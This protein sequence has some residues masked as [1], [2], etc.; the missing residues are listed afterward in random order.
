MRA[1]AQQ[2]VTLGAPPYRFGPGLIRLVGT[3]LG[4]AGTKGFVQGFGLDQLVMQLATEWLALVSIHHDGEVQVIGRLGDQ[5]DRIVRERLHRRRQLGQQRADTTPNQ[6]DSGTVFQHGNP[7]DP[8]Q[9]GLE[10][11]EHCGRECG[12]IVQR[13]G[14]AG[15]R[16]RDQVDRY[17]MA[18]EGL[19]RLGQEAGGSPHAAGVKGDQ[20]HAIL[21]RNRLQA[22]RVL[23][24]CGTD[25]RARQLAFV[26]AADF[27]LDTGIADGRDGARMQD[28]G[29]H[30]GDFLGLVITQ[31]L[32]LAGRAGQ[33]R[34]GGEK[35]RHIGPDFQPFRLQFGGKICGGRIRASASQEGG[36]AILA[37][38]DK[39]LGQDN[40]TDEA[41]LQ[42]LV[43]SVI[44]VGVHIA[45][46]TAIRARG[47]RC[48]GVQPFT[49]ATGLVEPRCAQR[50]RHQLALAKNSGMQAR[51]G[52][53]RQRQAG[54]EPVQLV[55]IGRQQGFAIEL[56][57]IGQLDMAC[58]DVGQRLAAITIAGRANQVLQRVGHTANG[59]VNDK[60][61]FLRLAEFLD[62]FGDNL[63]VREGFDTRSTEFENDPVA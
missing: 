38:G 50:R 22:G 46:D 19:E 3:Q 25:H 24:R 28:R 29:P 44:A 53:T 51:A 5:T 26:W 10:R 33:P 60:H 32:D 42:L 56:Q 2:H 17:A 37:P 11:G 43:R 34:I 8:G 6:A 13:H 57:L 41:F 58:L 36:V 61:P 55:E 31:R 63:P 39:A 14:H 35:S 12:V 15:F 20:T 48:A 52:I 45:A 16:G 59:R 7:G 27:H 9:I 21:D 30:G 40:I 23:G 4:P 47:E 49:I 1:G 54:T 62:P 18:R